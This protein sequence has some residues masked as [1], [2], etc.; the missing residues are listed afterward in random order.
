MSVRLCFLE[1]RNLILAVAEWMRRQQA[2]FGKWGSP[3]VLSQVDGSGPGP[4]WVQLWGCRG[5][6]VQHPHASAAVL[7]PE[8]GA[9]RLPRSFPD[10]RQRVSSVEIAVQCNHSVAQH[11]KAQRTAGGSQAARRTKHSRPVE[12]PRLPSERR[13]RSGS[14]GHGPQRRTGVGASPARPA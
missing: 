13:Q 8:F 3:L 11:V 14:D 2:V 5:E 6:E 9:R 7:H 10:P 1:D 4:F 12:G